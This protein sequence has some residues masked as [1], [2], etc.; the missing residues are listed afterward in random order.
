MPS[1]AYV[2]AALTTILLVTFA[3]RALP[4]AVLEPLRGSTFMR[5]LSRYMPV[6][7]MT[8]LVV[9]TLKDV[10]LG[11]GWHGLP[12]AIALAV[13]VGLHLWRHNALLSILGGTGVYVLLVNTVLASGVA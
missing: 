1:D 9:Y 3:L 7:I 5:F 13:T 6:G 11:T 4:F 10:S 12:E 8:I 2:L